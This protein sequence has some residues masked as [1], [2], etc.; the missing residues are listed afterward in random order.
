MSSG[1]Y[2]SGNM[3]SVQTLEFGEFITIGN[4]RLR[5]DLIKA[6][7]AHFDKETQKEDHI[8]IFMEGGW[9]QA[10]VGDVQ[11]TLKWLDSLFKKQYGL[12]GGLEVVSES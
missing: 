9:F 11:A 8:M 3:S 2:I 10:D 7:M 6:Y 4:L 5:K 1:Q 12:N